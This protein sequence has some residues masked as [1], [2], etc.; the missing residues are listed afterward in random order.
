MKENRPAMPVGYPRLVDFLRSV[1]SRPGGTGAILNVIRG[2]KVRGAADM[3]ALTDL[4]SDLRLKLDLARHASD[5][6]RHA[7][8]LL[9]RMAELGFKAF[10][11]P[12]ELDRVEG[13]FARS[14]AREVRQVYAE[15]GWVSEAE[16]MELTVTAFILENDAVKKIRANHEALSADPRT[17]AVIGEML[18]DDERHVAYLTSW[19]ERFEQRFSRRAVVRTRERLEEVSSQLDF[20]YYGTLQ[21]Y[22]ERTAV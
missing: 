2:C 3:T 21:E 11:L 20:V 4:V 13:L 12:A 19:L 18:A 17:Q 6:A 5:E 8:A 22:F 1:H 15:R 10:R 9:Q 7:Y 16:L 14:R